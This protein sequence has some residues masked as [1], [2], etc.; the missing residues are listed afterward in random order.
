[1]SKNAPQAETK[2]PYQPRSL[3]RQIHTCNVT[4]G[5]I[6]GRRSGKGLEN[7]TVLIDTGYVLGSGS[8]QSGRRGVCHLS[9]A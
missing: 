9:D 1:M 3:V 2:N 6:E 5:Y 4:R 8:L 7:K